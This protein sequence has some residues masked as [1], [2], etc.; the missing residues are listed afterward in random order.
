M[1]RQFSSSNK[2]QGRILILCTALL[3]GLAGV[4]VKSI[5]WS[6]L[7]IIAVRSIISLIMLFIYNRS[8]RIRFTKANILGGLAMSITGILY[9]MAIKLTTA[10]TAIVLQYIAPILVFLYAIL[11]KGR[12][13]RA[14]EIILTL[15]VFAG[16]VLSFAG[17]LDFTHILGNL[18]ALCSGFTYAAQ[19]IIM[20]S[21][22]CDSIDCTIISNGICFIVCFPF[23]FFDDLVFDHGN[24]IWLLILAVFQYGLPN[25]LFSKGIKLTDSVEASVL[26]SVEPVINPI[27]VAVFCGEIMDAPAVIGSA[28]VII[29][30]AL[31]SILPRLSRTEP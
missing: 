29:S 4:C 23:M 26:L 14:A 9:V 15:C 17:S 31:Y 13:A 2:T 7:S 18:I 25:I 3:W 28:M 5:T 10:G 24:I 11:F 6:S 20:N 8:F 27:L 22:S 12:K 16:C 30:V 19:I 21:S 1:S